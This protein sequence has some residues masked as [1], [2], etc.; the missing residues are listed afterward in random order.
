MA[1]H[2]LI[3]RFNAGDGKFPFVSGQFSKNHR[4]IPIEATTYY[5]VRAAAWRAAFSRETSEQEAAY[6]KQQELMEIERRE[7][8]SFSYIDFLTDF[9]SE[10]HDI[11]ANARF[12]G[13]LER[14]QPQSVSTFGCAT[15]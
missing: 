2:A 1:N 3:A 8:E 5:P 12:E 11:R 10:F 9:R 7:K 14:S 4:P 15:T 13:C 6:H